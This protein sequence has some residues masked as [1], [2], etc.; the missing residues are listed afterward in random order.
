ML[1]NAE[2]AAGFQRGEGLLEDL[3][4]VPAGHPIVHVAE[5]QNEVGLALRREPV[6]FGRQ[7]AV[8]D[9]AEEFRRAAISLLKA[10]QRPRR[11]FRGL[12]IEHHGGVGPIACGEIGRDHLRVPAAAGPDLDHRLVR[13]EAEKLKRFLRVPPSIARTLLL[14]SPVAGKR[15]FERTGRRAGG[16][17]RL[18][19][20]SRFGRLLR[21]GRGRLSGPA[22]RKCQ[23][24]KA[25]RR[26][27][28]HRSSPGVHHL[29]GR[30]PY[31]NYTMSQRRQ[32]GLRRDRLAGRVR[33][34]SVLL[35]QRRGIAAM[36]RLRKD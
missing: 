5:G 19:R 3:G 30:C 2:H 7:E 25:C 31:P 29:K 12:G 26:C 32:A 14:G 34:S 15:P 35:H 11:A 6:R 8:F 4:L 13:L 10:L 20:R 18:D 9:L 16:F 23:D 33:R 1:D 17:G 27:V 36:G 21:G 28:L 22:S 24:G